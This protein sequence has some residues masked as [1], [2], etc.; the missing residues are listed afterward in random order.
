MSTEAKHGLFDYL[1][2][3]EKERVLSRLKKKELQQGECLFKIGDAAV[4][5]FYVVFGRFAVKKNTGFEDKMQVVAL[6]ETGSIIGEGA[7]VEEHPRTVT[8]VAVDKS[9]VLELSQKDYADIKAESPG[10]ALKLIEYN[11]KI[12]ALRLNACTTRLA[13]IL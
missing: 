13:H 12:S 6:L 7:I 5:M 8:I 9:E 1:S 10:I 2:A 4:S 3:A 11:S